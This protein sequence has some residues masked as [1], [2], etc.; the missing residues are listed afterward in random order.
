MI[1]ALR[2]QRP[3]CAVPLWELEFHLWGRF[4]GRH[5][6]LGEEFAALSA[7]KQECA[8]EENADIILSV[9]RQL[10]FAA[11]SAPTPPWEQSPGVPAY[12]ILPDE[13]P[14]RQVAA[15]R[16]A[17]GSEL[18]IVG[19]GTAVL[20]ANYDVE[21]C[22][23]LVES[24]ETIEAMAD[25]WLARGLETARRL[26]DLGVE[27]VFTASDIADNNGPFFR[28]SQMERF[29]LPYL[30]RWAQE[31]K[32]MG[33]FTILHTDGRLP[34]AWLAAIADTAV[35]ALQAIDPVAGMDLVST[36]A[37]VGDR[38]CLCGNVDCGLLL[39]GTPEEVHAVTTHLLQTCK[40]GGGWVLGASNAV[41]RTVP[42]ENYRAMLTAWREYGSYQKSDVTHKGG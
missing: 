2:R 23:A 41:E 4:S 36:K 35:D 17:A 3:E 32:A 22:A 38:L 11:I 31:C 12:Y 29:I 20:C 9:C 27:A 18:M 6:V 19:H 13:A 42:A 21:F 8:L 25:Q 30:D 1:A 34:P 14:F 40:A 5:V 28:M 37:L 39:S 10:G 16:K 26:R 24:P 15:L 7:A 33:L